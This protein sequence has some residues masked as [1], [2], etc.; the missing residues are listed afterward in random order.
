M[1]SFTIQNSQLLIIMEMLV[2]EKSKTKKAPKKL[3]VKDFLLLQQETEEVFE[4]ENGVLIPTTSMK[5]RERIIVSNILRAFAQTKAYKE[6]AELLP[7]TDCWLTETQ[8]RRLDIA[9][10]TR[11]QIKA[12]A[13]GENPVPVFVIEIISINDSINHV[14]G[15]VKEYFEAGISLVW[16]IFPDLQMVRISKNPK[17]A[18]HYFEKDAFDASPVIKDLKM[19]VEELFAK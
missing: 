17:E 19:N 10:F 1:Y 15:K 2:L 13:E 14:E 3:S 8:M 18:H 6:L 9:F 7:E 12:A 4:Y 16:H 11:A 5:N